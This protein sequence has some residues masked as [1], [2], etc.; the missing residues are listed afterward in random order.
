MDL[1]ALTDGSIV[2][3]NV[4]HRGKA[5][6]DHAQLVPNHLQKLTKML[7]QQEDP[8]ADAQG[9]GP[10][11]TASSGFHEFMIYFVASNYFSQFI[12]ACILLNSVL[13][14]LEVDPSTTKEAAK[15]YE[16]IDLVFIVVYS[17]EFLMKNYV[18]FTGYWKNNYNRF[19][20]FLLALSYLS[21]G[22]ALNS[23]GNFSVFRI[24]RTFRAFR[25]FRGISFI[26]SLQVIVTA[27]IKTM[28]TIFNLVLLLLLFIFVFGIV[29]L[30]FFGESDETRSDWGS[31]GRSMFTLFVF[32]T[33]DNWGDIQDKMDDAVGRSSRVFTVIFIFLGNLIFTNLFIGI[34]IQNLDEATEE[35]RRIQKLKRQKVISRKKAFILERQQRDLQKLL[36][37]QVSSS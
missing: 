22:G 10:Q 21:V 20:A 9:E 30:N 5:K 1:Y 34:V 33:A 3:K 32:V 17:I 8:D 16:I 7:E 18:D 14:A 23:Q 11:I 36:E 31:L 29:G 24:L 13:L 28:S 27:L 35:D 2:S 4:K 19:D 6:N 12:M 37:R 25:A 26:R 15:V